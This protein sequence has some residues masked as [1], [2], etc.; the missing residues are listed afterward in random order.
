MESRF[1]VGCKGLRSCVALWENRQTTDDPQKTK[2]T[3]VTGYG[4]RLL[5]AFITV[6]VSLLQSLLSAPAII[7]RSM[8]DFQRGFHR[9]D[10]GSHTVEGNVSGSRAAMLERKRQ[11]E[12]EEFEL[13]KQK[14]IRGAE[15]AALNIGSKFQPARIGSVVG[16]VRIGTRG[17]EGH[18]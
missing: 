3:T 15:H 13:E 2:T 18:G 11:A 10:A 7:Y 9:P 12:Q 6:V 16:A 5:Y 14:R 4:L 8:G 17:V 1:Y